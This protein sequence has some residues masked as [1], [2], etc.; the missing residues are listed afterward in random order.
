M[1]YGHTP[2][3]GIPQAIWDD[4]IDLWLNLSTAD[5]DDIK[6]IAERLLAVSAPAAPIPPLAHSGQCLTIAQDA[7]NVWAEKP[8]NKRWF[9]RIDGTLIPNDLPVVMAVF[10]GAQGVLKYRQEPTKE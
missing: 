3:E 1:S 6:T 4:A 5:S 2:P 8:H 7:F 9:K 10:F